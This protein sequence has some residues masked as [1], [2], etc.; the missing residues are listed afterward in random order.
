MVRLRLHRISRESIKS[1]IVLS[2]IFVSFNDNHRVECGPSAQQ[3]HELMLL[4]ALGRKQI[5]NNNLNSISSSNNN[6]YETNSIMDMLGRSKLILPMQF[7]DTR[8]TS[9]VQNILFHITA[10]CSC[11]RN[12][13]IYLTKSLDRTF[14]SNYIRKSTI[15][16]T[17]CGKN[18]P[19][20]LKIN[21]IKVIQN[22]ISLSFGQMF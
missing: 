14:F 5:N 6:N 11:S 10:L 13:K 8:C 16:N 3:E 9:I 2:L 4:D 17:K 19:T 12:P 22:E 1:V 20:V 7:Q 15:S 18:H 21:I